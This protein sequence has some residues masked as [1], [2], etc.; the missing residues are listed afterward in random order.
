MNCPEANELGPKQCRVPVLSLALLLERERGTMK[1][2]V[3]LG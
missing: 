1:Q 3:F 2:T